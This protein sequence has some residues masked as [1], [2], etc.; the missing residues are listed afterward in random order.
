VA[1]GSARLSSEPT[2][3]FWS[4]KARVHAMLA[5]RAGS[6]R[7]A[8]AHYVKATVLFAGFAVSYTVVVQSK[9][10]SCLLLGSISTG[11][12]LAGLAFNVQH[13]GGHGA[14]SDRAW[15]NRAAAR[16]LD[17]LGMSSY[18][19]RWKHNHL[20]HSSPN[21]EGI[22]NDLD[23]SQLLR[24][25]PEQRLHPWHRFQHVYCWFLYPFATLKWALFSDI[26]ELWR[27]RIGGF[28]FPAMEA[29]AVLGFWLSKALF[30]SWAFTLPS[31]ALGA[32][33]GLVFFL[34]F[35]MTGGFIAALTFQLAHAV[36]EAEHLCLAALPDLSWSE[37]QLASTVDFR[38]GP[39]LQWFAGGLNHQAAHHL[40]PGLRHTY[41]PRV[42]LL[43]EAEARKHGISYRCG[44]S[45]SYQVRSHY[46]L[47][48]ALGNS[49]S[50]VRD[51]SRCLEHR[52]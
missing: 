10:T 36:E 12:A 27:G 52:E 35:Q 33:R 3:F 20:H 16:V 5:D 28:A 34:V 23:T 47:L 1:T 19:W 48:R 30:I 49:D 42:A 21:V 25:H 22:D 24:L 32:G 11:I 44:R 14:F 39:V 17:C 51:R 43:L 4:L 15:A 29:D 31:L 2:D 18:L 40:F 26:R 50:S 45:L 13:D 7:A 38:L 37:R 8:L 6:R 46:R 9:T 41:Y